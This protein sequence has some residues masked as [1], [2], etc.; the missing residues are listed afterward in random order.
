MTYVPTQQVTEDIV[1]NWE[2]LVLK[3][4]NKEAF[5]SEVKIII[6]KKCENLGVCPTSF[7]VRQAGSLSL[8]F[9][10]MLTPCVITDIFIWLAY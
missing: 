10:L 4:R 5:W 1:I 3:L 2:G 8:A 6:G 7:S 9:G